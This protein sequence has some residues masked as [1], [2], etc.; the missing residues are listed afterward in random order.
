MLQQIAG[1]I[2]NGASFDE[3]T[4]VEAPV[5]IRIEHRLKR[6]SD[7][8]AKLEQRQANLEE[9]M[10]DV[11]QELGEQTGKLD[12]LVEAAK[13]QFAVGTAH[14]VA[15]IEVGKSRRIAT[16]NDEADR[17]SWRRKL[18][19]KVTGG[20]LAVVAAAITAIEAALGR[21]G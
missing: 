21:C 4:P 11:R 20:A 8:Y 17:A 15:D 16:I 7:N 2:D 12:I 18:I 6:A 10:G 13:G 19:L 3:N 1:E 9:Q 14:V 5:L